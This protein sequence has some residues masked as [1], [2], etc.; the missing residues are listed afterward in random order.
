MPDRAHGP[1]LGAFLVEDL[2]ELPPVR[3]AEAAVETSE[4]VEVER[5]WRAQAVGAPHG[6]DLVEEHDV[7][8][9][10]C[11]GHA[12]GE[13][14]GEL[15]SGPDDPAEP[16]LPRRGRS[17]IDLL[18]REVVRNVARN[19]EV[20]PRREAAHLQP[21]GLQAAQQAD[22]DLSGRAALRQRRLGEDDEYAEPGDGA[23]RDGFGG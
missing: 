23:D 19:G 3:G 14:A 15:A 21:V 9:A 22:R 10:R 17:D 13:G 4:V 20:L 16:R 5:V 6:L 8:V 2:A 7:G 11:L 18:H 1:P 12:R